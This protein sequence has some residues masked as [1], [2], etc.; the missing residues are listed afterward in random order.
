V[1]KQKK[2][3]KLGLL[4][5]ALA[6]G[7]CTGGHPSG[8]GVPSP[9]AS[10]S[11]ADYLAKANAVCTAMNAK[12]NAL[13]DPGQ[14]PAKIRQ[15][16]DQAIPLAADGL[17]QLRQLPLPQ[18]DEA[19]VRDFYAKVD[20]LIADLRAESAALAGNDLTRARQLVSSVQ[21]DS[22]AANTAANAYGLTVCGS[23]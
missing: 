21:A 11:K 12:G 22:A 6:L 1:V 23:A 17:A 5:A 9:A 10:I 7:A 2:N 20:G 4:V 3:V 8:G 18:G 15:V 13:Q 19:A 14:D 16:V